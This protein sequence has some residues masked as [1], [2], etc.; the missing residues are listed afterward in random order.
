[1]RVAPPK[2]PASGISPRSMSV[3]SGLKSY[4]MSREWMSEVC[5]NVM[6]TSCPARS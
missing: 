4:G 2:G 6:R 1:M 3:F 5:M